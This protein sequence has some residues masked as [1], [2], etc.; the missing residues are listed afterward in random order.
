M[1]GEVVGEMTDGM[2]GGMTGDMVGGMT[3]G[4][5]GEMTDGMIEERTDGMLEVNIMKTKE[6]TTASGTSVGASKRDANQK[7]KPGNR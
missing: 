1:T 4:M 5:V 7:S 3:D 6:G 2:V